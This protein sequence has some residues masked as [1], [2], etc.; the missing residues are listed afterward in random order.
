MKT[1]SL[2]FLFFSLTAICQTVEMQRNENIIDEK[3]VS[4][5]KIQTQFII[6]NLNTQ[7]DFSVFAESTSDSIFSIF[8]SNN[9]KDSISLSKQDWHLYIIQEAKN[10]EGDWKPIEYWK[11]SWCGNS[12]LS[13]TLKSNE[14]IKTESKAYKGIFKTEIRF[15]LLLNSKNYYSNAIKGEIDPNQ[16]DFNDSI[17]DKSGYDNYSK[18]AGNKTAEKM[19]F[20]ESSGMR[21]YTE[22]N[23]KYV[24]WLTKKAKKRNKAK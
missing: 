20:L 13:Q 22:K 14:I 9:L 2:Y 23:K 11:N 1:L 19:I 17:K 6:L 10:K 7:K 5:S 16:F 12:Y 24:A 3:Y 15:K 4:D 8:V 21:E 18:R